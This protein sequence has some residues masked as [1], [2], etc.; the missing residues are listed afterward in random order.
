MNQPLAVMAA[1]LCLLVTAARAADT[2]GDSI[3]QL[4]PALTDQAGTALGLDHYRGAPVLIS[5]FFAS[6]GYVCPTLIRRIQ[7]YESQLEPA[8]RARLR[9]LLVSF[10]TEHDT[11]EVLASLAKK[12]SADLQ[13]WSFT[14]ASAADVRKLAA[15]LSIQYR[16]LPD[17]GFNH[18]SVIALLDAEGRVLARSERPGAEDASL[19]AALAAATRY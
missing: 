17:G 9:V 12:H 13:R 10:D 2:P 5:M 15:L 7:H 4:K 18:A 14:R 6:C 16:E 8:Q 11:P 19:R 3:Y 1:A